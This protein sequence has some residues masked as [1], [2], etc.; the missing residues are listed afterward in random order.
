[1]VGTVTSCCMLKSHIIIKSAV[2]ATKLEETTTCDW[3]HN[4]VTSLSLTEL[5]RLSQKCDWT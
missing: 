3:R 5:F 4:I 2:T 1:M